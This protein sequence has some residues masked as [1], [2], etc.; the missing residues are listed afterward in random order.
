MHAFTIAAIVVA[1]ITQSKASATDRDWAW[2][3]NSSVCTLDQEFRGE[4][5]SLT[6]SRT[7]GNGATGVTVQVPGKSLVRAPV[8]DIKVTLEPGGP[9][10]ATAYVGFD[11]E[12]P[13]QRVVSI[14]VE[15]QTF[16]DRLAHA[17]S[18]TLEGK[19]VD[20]RRVIIRSAGAAVQALRRCEDAKMRSWGIDP[21][22]WRALRSPPVQTAEP[23][24]THK[25]YPTDRVARGSSGKVVV[26]MT[27]SGDGAVK[28]CVSLLPRSG[29]TF[30]RAVCRAFTKR[31]RFAPAQDSAGRP[32]EAPYVAYVN[33]VMLG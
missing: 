11:P 21:V 22:A 12:H 18:I 16:L 17:A 7:P 13:L 1:A 10:S 9:V 19:R 27:V 4:S 26:R 33:F 30:V 3:N 31:A 15:D 20:Q 5:G 23:V 32:V 6:I 8:P 25:D 29:P 2:D 24:I 14:T 28:D